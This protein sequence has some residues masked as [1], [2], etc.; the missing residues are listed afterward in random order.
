MPSDASWIHIALVSLVLGLPC[1]ALAA[2]GGSTEGAST[3]EPAAV[4]PSDAWNVLVVSVD[5][6]RADRMALYGHDRDTTP[7]LDRFA[8]EAVVF[9]RCFANGAW[10]SPGIASMMTGV[11]AP[12]HGQDTRYDYTDELLVTPLDV[13][14]A[15]GLRTISR[16]SEGATYRGLGFQWKYRP[17][18]HEGVEVAEWL[19]G[20]DERWLAWVHV[21][22]THLPYDPP[23][24]H[25]RRFGGDR[26]DTPAVRA[27][28][29]NTTVYPQD[30]G[31]S[32]NPPVI[33]AFTEEE[34][35]V[36]RDLYDG[37]VAA[38]DDLLG[39]M[40]E[41]LRERGVLDRTVVILTADHGEELFD[42][43]WVG[44]AS[45]GYQGKVYDELLHI[46]LIVRLPGG[47]AHGR[48]DALVQQHDVMPTLFELLGAD[49][50]ATDYAFQ[51]RSLVPLIEGRDGATGHERVF[52]R[53]TFKGWTTPL[54]EAGDGATAVRDGSRKLIR[55]RRD[56]KL[57]HEAYDLASDP[58]E[59][60]DLWPD[61]A[62]DFAD[63]VQALDAW[64]AENVQRGGDLLITAAERRVEA[65]EEAA[66]ARDAAAAAEHWLALTELDR[67]YRTEWSPPQDDP[68][69]R[70]SWQRLLRRA[71]ALR[72]RASR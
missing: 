72:D 1:A 11:H 12:V 21:K 16:E 71:R 53:T 31:L 66:R 49:A 64:E 63:L 47:E 56:G 55:L 67:T 35:A 60:T 17:V 45:T 50:S 65:L 28:R 38:A 68:A 26:L 46:P 6:L 23:P 70:G 44:H 25:L 40:M 41:T 15:Q 36:V 29:D 8:D 58:G 57:S 14:R 30:Y 61:K 20:L 37:E 69:F 19:A 59:R 34:Q 54:A 52:A 18:L 22:P 9:D 24:Y 43:G 3:S 39:R 2:G 7:Y 42:H 48:V 13:L 51:G 4:A 33:E 62:G 10:T 32:W 5:A 27:V